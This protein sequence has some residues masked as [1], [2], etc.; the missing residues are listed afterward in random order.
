MATVDTLKR[1]LRNMRNPSGRLPDLGS[2]IIEQS[3]ESWTRNAEAPG[4]LALVATG[5]LDHGPGSSAVDR[6]DVGGER[7]S[8]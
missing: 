4:R 8:A 6:V 7:Q 3:V 5:E 2:G 1:A